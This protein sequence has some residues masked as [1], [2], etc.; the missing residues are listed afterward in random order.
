MFQ[1]L[2]WI[3][4]LSVVAS[5]IALVVIYHEQITDFSD[6]WQ[7][8]KEA[9]KAVANENFDK[10]IDL[11]EKGMTSHANNQELAVALADLYRIRGGMADRA[12]AEALYQ[13]L[14]EA[15][16][17]NLTARVGY[18]DLLSEDPARLNEAVSQSRDAL[19]VHQGEASVLSTLGDVFKRAAENPCENRPKMRHWLYD[20]AIYYYRNALTHHPK[21]YATQ[22]NLGV[23]YQ[24]NDQLE[25]AATHYCNALLLS[26]GRYEV[27][28][29]LG[30][31]LSELR[32]VEEGYRHLAYSLDILRESDRMDQARQL[33]EQIQ[34]F[35]SSLF[36]DEKYSGLAPHAEMPEGF[37]DKRCLLPVK[38]ASRA[39]TE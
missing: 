37:L 1:A 15:S 19:R 30:L 6:T 28:Y 36:Q 4:G 22:F 16:P 11:Y 21:H 29:N 33:A 23:A 3:L 39:S 32:L 8:Q 17:G 25:K 14:L 9:N 2:K 38:D 24:Q 7:L 18:I 10:A 26:P 20:W 13:K 35:K 34:A 31:V 5:L 27:H 12:K